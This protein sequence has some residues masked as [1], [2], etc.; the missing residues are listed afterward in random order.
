MS[1]R[2][3]KVEGAGIGKGLEMNW[4]EAEWARGVL[5]QVDLLTGV[6]VSSVHALYTTGIGIV[7]VPDYY[8]S[9]SVRYN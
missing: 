3:W 7:A 8:Q 5:T 1:S 9:L 6:Q 2:N 4:G